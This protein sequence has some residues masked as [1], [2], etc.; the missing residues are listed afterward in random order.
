MAS[1]LDSIFVWEGLEQQRESI[2]PLAIGGYRIIF[3]IEKGRSGMFRTDIGIINWQWIRK[4]LECE[5]TFS[6]HSK[7]CWLMPKSGWHIFQQHE[8]AEW[9][10]STGEVVWVE[11]SLPETAC[12][13]VKIQ[14][15][16]S[17]EL[18]RGALPLFLIVDSYLSFPN[19]VSSSVKVW[20]NNL[21]SLDIC[22]E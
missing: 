11:K 14:V 17:Y 9:A 16:E 19:S 10:G 12:V 13:V 18:M 3:F 7:W 8:E 20:N 5:W 21:Y 1:T 22:E 4:S 2:I 15:L 6:W